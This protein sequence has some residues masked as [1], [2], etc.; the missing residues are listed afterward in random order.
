MIFK[1]IL[2]K[3]LS[4]FGISTYGTVKKKEILKI[5]DLLRPLNLGHDYIRLGGISDGSYIVPKIL[6]DI[7][8]VFLLVMEEIVLLKK[9]RKFGIK[10]FWL[11]IRLTLQPNLRI[12]IIKKFGKSYSSNNSININDWIETSVSLN[13]KKMILQIDVEGSEY[14]IIH[15]IT[16]NNLQKFD[17][18]VIEFHNLF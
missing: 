1:K 18:I 17:I 15:A 10:S 4:N 9:F 12:L 3:I 6:N 14:E 5:I 13:Q 2:K 7:N 11:T 16:E 8:S